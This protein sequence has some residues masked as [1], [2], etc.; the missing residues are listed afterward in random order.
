MLGQ[1]CPPPR[2]HLSPSHPLQSVSSPS[3]GAWSPTNRCVCMAL[4]V[5]P[6]WVPAALLPSEFPPGLS[7]FPGKASFCCS[8]WLLL[9]LLPVPGGPPGA[10]Q[11]PLSRQQPLESKRIPYPLLGQTP[12]HP[13]S[14]CY[15]RLKN[16]A[17]SNEIH[18]A[19]SGL[20][21]PN[22]LIELMLVQCLGMNELM[23]GV[24]D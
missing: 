23:K 14:C 9:I 21:K 4:A 22:V 24:S 8:V 6:A 17:S 15:P 2:L 20:S 1:A 7:C 13:G 11:P 18:S 3:Y 16:E 12:S 19:V 10:P 5:F